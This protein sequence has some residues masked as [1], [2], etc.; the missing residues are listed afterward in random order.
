MSGPDQPRSAANR[1]VLARLLE[2]E[3]VL[4]S[5]EPA[6]TVIPE[7]GPRTVLHCGPPLEWTAMIDPLRGAIIGAILYEGWA[8]T[9]A[10]ALELIEDG[11]IRLSPSSHHRAGAPLAGVISPSMPAFVVHNRRFGTTAYTNLNEGLGRT[12]R[13]GAY[14]EAVLER[15]TWMESALAPTLST[16]LEGCGPIEL[17]PIIANALTRGDEC[18]NRNAAASD[19]LSRVLTP[20]LFRSDVDRDVAAD[21]IEFIT[22]NEHFFL[23]LSI[24]AALSTLQAAQDVPNSSIVTRLC[25]NGTKFGLQVSAS[26]DRWFTAPAIT[27]DGNFLKGYDKRDSAT[28]FGDSLVTEATGLGG[29]AL[30]G[31]PAISDYLGITA[32]DCL[33]AT[34]RM[35]DIT[36]GEHDMFTLPAL[37]GRGTPLGIDLEA[38]VESSTPPVFNAGIA[39]RIRGNGQ[40][41]AGLAQVPLELFE[42]AWEA[43]S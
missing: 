18:H 37:D 1:T 41:G 6:G 9:E 14:D 30:A 43:I 33:D 22:S 26:G 38:V 21:A 16:A 35:Y 36:A 39:H 27:P 28:V 2:A 32:A 42:T 11:S 3:P 40:V 12:L 24:G 34:T 17:K 7:M 29:F 10:Q 15:L 31:A 25:T 13:F 20:A 8:E 23:N 19:L 5:I 4:E